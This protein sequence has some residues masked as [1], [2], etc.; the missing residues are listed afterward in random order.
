MLKYVGSLSL[1]MLLLSGANSFGEEKKPENEKL[2]MVSQYKVAKYSKRDKDFD[3]TITLLFKVRPGQGVC[4]ITK[5]S[6]LIAV[7]QKGEKTLLNLD[8]IYNRTYPIKK[9]GRLVYE[10]S[11]D[12]SLPKGTFCI[13]GDLF[14]RYGTDLKTIPF[15][16]SKQKTTV[17]EGMYQFHVSS[18]MSRADKNKIDTIFVSWTD[19]PSF[20]QIRYKNSEAKFVNVLFLGSRVRN[21]YTILSFHAFSEPIEEGTPGEI[22]A[23]SKFDTKKFP[24]KLSVSVGVTPDPPTHYLRAQ[25]EKQ[26]ELKNGNK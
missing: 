12:V 11:F 22:L 9:L 14:V 2:F 24:F 21:S 4:E 16:F 1:L 23:W 7:N 15:I 17:T 10:V 6:S 13:E 25:A 26:E 19:S 18:H 20:H 5:D 8:S 3:V